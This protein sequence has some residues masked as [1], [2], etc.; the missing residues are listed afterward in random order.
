MTFSSQSRS[1]AILL[2]ATHSSLRFPPD[3][4]IFSCHFW[5]ID[6]CNHF[7]PSDLTIGVATLDIP[8]LFS[9]WGDCLSTGFTQSSATQPAYHGYSSVA[10]SPKMTSF[11]SYIL[12]LTSG[13]P[14]HQPLVYAIASRTEQFHSVRHFCL[15]IYRTASKQ[16]ASVFCFQPMTYFP[17]MHI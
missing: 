2:R 13:F 12:R 15:L 3:I 8:T 10:E 11:F 5:L 7:L 9:F 6:N 17:P 16:I 1:A 14:F 4:F